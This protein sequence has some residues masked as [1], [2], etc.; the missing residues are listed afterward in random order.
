MPGL[1]F[2]GDEAS[3]AGFRL[4]GV[5]TLSPA[6]A[7]A[8]AAVREALA[9]EPDLLMLTAEYARALAPS[10]LAQLLNAL[11]PLTLLMADL[12]GHVMPDELAQQVRRQLGLVT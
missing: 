7:G 6:P 9:D 11:Q 5:R 1:F 8:V 3:A 12:P 4:A 2:I 10:D